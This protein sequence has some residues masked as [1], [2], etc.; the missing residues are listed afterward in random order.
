MNKQGGKK[1]PINEQG[2]KFAN[3]VGQKKWK[4]G[5]EKSKNAN[6]VGSFI[7]HLRVASIDIVLS[8]RRLFTER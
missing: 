7:W 5:G 2:G 4:Q 6:Q 1:C 3:Q 8:V